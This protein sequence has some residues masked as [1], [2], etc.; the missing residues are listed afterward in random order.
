MNLAVKDIGTVVAAMREKWITADNSYLTSD[1]DIVTADGGAAPFYTYG[2]RLEIA[3]GLVEKGKDMVNKFKKYPL[4]A[5]N[6][7]FPE[8]KVNGIVQLTLNIGIIT[9]TGKNLRTSK[10]FDEAFTKTL[11]PLY[12]LFFEE[13]RNSGLFFW[14]DHQSMPPHTEFKRPYWGTEFSE[15]SERNIFDDPIDAIEITDLKINQDV[16]TRQPCL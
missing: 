3:R 11:I 12:E 1:S 4:I 7:P 13:L 10:R 16:R 2:H 6:M 15:G 14:P 8:V 5:L 9:S